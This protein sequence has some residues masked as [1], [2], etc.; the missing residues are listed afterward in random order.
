MPKVGVRLLL[1][2]IGHHVRFYAVVVSAHISHYVWVDMV[3]IR[4][5]RRRVSH[6]VPL[7]G[8]TYLLVRTITSCKSICRHRCWGVSL[9]VFAGCPLEEAGSD[10]PPA[11]CP[12]PLR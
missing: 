5:C 1:H 9:D 3:S 7:L 10:K 4:P 12:F 6:F 2:A 11:I 8:L